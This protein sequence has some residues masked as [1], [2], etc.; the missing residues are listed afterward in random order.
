MTRYRQHHLRVPG[1]LA[2]PVPLRF[3]P[4]LLPDS[5]ESKVQL[6]GAQLR[7]LQF[8][9]HFALAPIFSI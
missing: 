1:D 9:Y 7:H 2:Q 5:G 6:A 8:K 4:P 3:L